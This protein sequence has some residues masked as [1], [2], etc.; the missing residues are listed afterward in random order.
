MNELVNK[1]QIQAKFK[2]DLRYPEVLFWNLQKYNCH[3]KNEFKKK[4]TQNKSM[5][6]KMTDFTVVYRYL[7]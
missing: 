4:T 7:M 3:G 5:L 2:T 1:Y 6:P